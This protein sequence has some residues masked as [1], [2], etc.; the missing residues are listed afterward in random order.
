[1]FALSNRS[2]VIEEGRKMQASSV[3]GAD[4]PGTRRRVWLAVQ[5]K[6]HKQKKINASKIAFFYYRLFFGIRSFQWVTVDS[7]KNFLPTP[8]LQCEGVSRKFPA[9]LFPFR[10]RPSDNA[11]RSAAN[12]YL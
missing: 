10:G 4:H 11:D 9:L 5:I 12:P 6:A 7:N 2:F 3:R 1:M 8:K